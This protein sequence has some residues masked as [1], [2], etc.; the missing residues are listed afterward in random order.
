MKMREVAG[1]STVLEELAKA[2]VVP[3]VP[4]SAENVVPMGKRA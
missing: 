2:A 1:E 3:L 4:R